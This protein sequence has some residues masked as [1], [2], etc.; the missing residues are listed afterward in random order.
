MEIR[1]YHFIK[2][3]TF[4]YWPCSTVIPV[5]AYSISDL[6]KP[7]LRAWRS[8]RGPE[9]AVLQRRGRFFIVFDRRLK[10][11]RWSRLRLIEPV[12][13]V[14]TGEDDVG[15]LPRWGWRTRI[16]GRTK[17]CSVGRHKYRWGWLDVQCLGW[18]WRLVSCGGKL[19]V[20]TT[21]T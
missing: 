5:T 14:R 7:F 9:D 15:V 16:N 13:L 2:I 6:Q 12:A 17:F 21:A 19:C 4:L 10:P 1:I 20:S 3:L 8:E 11:K 18:L